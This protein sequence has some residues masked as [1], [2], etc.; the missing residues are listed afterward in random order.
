MRLWLRQTSLEICSSIKVLISVLKERAKSDIDIL[1]PG[2]THLQRAQPI[3]WSHFLLSHAFAFKSDEERLHQLLLSPTC[4]TMQ[5][6]LGSG[7]IAGTPFAIDRQLLAESLQFT[8]TTSNSMFGVGDRS[9]VIDFLYACTMCCLHMSRLCEDLITYSSMEFGFVQLADAYSTGSS[10]M[11]QKKNPDSLELVRG[12]CGRVFGN[13]TAMM[14][15]YKGLPST[16]N[17]DLQ[18]DKEGMI[19]SRDTVQMCLYIVSNVVS[20]LK[21]NEK[22]MRAALSED[23]L[24]TDVA[25]YLVRKSVPFRQA[26]HIAGQ[27][28]LCAEQLSREDHTIS[29]LQPYLAITREQWLSFSDKFEEDI[30][31][32]EWWSFERSVE[33]RKVKGGTARSSALAQ[34]AELEK[35]ITRSFYHYY[36]I[37]SMD[38]SKFRVKFSVWCDLYYQGLLQSRL[39]KYNHEKLFFNH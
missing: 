25:E 5:C 19:D 30:M 15:T 31:K 16:Y 6:P 28:V 23:M 4:A 29:T 13:L 17:K 36:L 38:V 8:G 11:P 20:S 32:P 24:A 3:R 35:Y 27:V 2:Y 26:H 10:L 14:M 9:F 39:A 12:K 21:T 33:S 1:M 22:K 18:E 34:I 7:A 37:H